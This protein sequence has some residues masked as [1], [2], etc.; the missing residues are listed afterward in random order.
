MQI[1]ML[2]GKPN[3][4]KTTTCHLVYQELKDWVTI[5]KSTYK[6]FGDFSC[7]F[8]FCYKKIAI[9][10]AGDSRYRIQ[11]VIEK[12]EKENFEVLVCTCRTNFIDIIELARQKSN[13]NLII[14][15]KD[16]ISDEEAKREIIDYL[17]NKIK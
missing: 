14:I 9:R 3:C 8:N 5:Y 10:S 2:V 17:K 13:K 16:N 7:S 12:C 4:G 11:S 15:D 6:D 1:I